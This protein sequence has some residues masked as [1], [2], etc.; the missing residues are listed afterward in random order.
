MK[1]SARIVEKA[2]EELNARRSRAELDASVRRAE[3]FRRFPE[4]KA[5]DEKISAASRE[6]LRIMTIREKNERKRQLD[7]LERENLELQRLLREFLENCGYAADCLEPRYFCSK[8]RDTGTRGG[9]TCECF[10]TLLKQ[11]AYRELCESSPLDLCSFDDFDLNY[12]SA[13]DG[14]N[15]SK[16]SRAI[17]ES[18]YHYCRMYADD[19]SMDSPNLLMYGGTGLGKTHLSLSIAGEVIDKGFAVIYDSCPNLTAKLD[20]EKFQRAEGDT[21]DTLM[22]CDL[23]I[24]DDLGAE[25]R[26]Q[27]TVSALY[28][29]INTRL[30]R[31]KP[32]IIST[33]LD[34]AGIQDIYQERIA[35]R[36]IGDYE[37]LRFVGRDIRQLKKSPDAR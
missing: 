24:I 8:C 18:I 12:Y 27:F 13:D 23:L 9:R 25:F 2:T 28:N 10:E 20:K 19:F 31:R 1:Y 36:I 4:A 34:I 30:L 26:N 17:M 14:N 35:S 6:F 33:N 11:T 29:I 3:I 37:L 32:T 22:D 5:I 7:A 21:E 15:G 16:S